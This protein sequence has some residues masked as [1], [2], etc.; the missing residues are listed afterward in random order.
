MEMEPLSQGTASRHRDQRARRDLQ[1]PDK[2]MNGYDQMN[3]YD[4][5]MWDALDDVRRRQLSHAPKRLIPARVRQFGHKAYDG[6]SSVPGFDQTE[7]FVEYVFGAASDVGAKFA[8]E[9]LATGRITGA[10]RKAGHSSVEN[11]SDIADLRLRDIDK[12]K[13][14]LGLRYIAAGVT[15]GAV[16]G[17]AVSGGELA[18]LVGGAAGGAAGGVAGG[19]VGA[20]PGAG[21]GAAPGAGG[22]V[23]AMAADTAAVLWGS[24]RA[25]F[26]TAAYYGYDV[27]RPEERLRAL[28]VLNYATAAGQ[29]AKNRAYIEA[30]KLAGMIVRNAAWKQLDQNLVTKIVRRIFEMLSIRLTKKSLAVAVP[31]VGVA[32]GAA[33]NGRTLQAAEEGADFLY[34]Q[35]FLCDKYDLPF[36]SGDA[37]KHDTAA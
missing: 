18:A 26:H 22:V 17:F 36:P 24:A 37:P 5:K 21:A 4:K 28:S 16:A 6:A 1:G 15:S 33:I 27:H 29:A 23:G 13:P 20:A 32:V 19:G 12:V 35:Q 7:D 2:P 9:S 10:Y 8:A 3:D 30:E 31:I 25:T 11:I 34:R 14:R